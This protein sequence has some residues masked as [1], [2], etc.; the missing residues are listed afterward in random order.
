[1]LPCVRPTHI[2][3][4]GTQLPALLWIPWPF[5]SAIWMSWHWQ[6]TAGHR[7]QDEDTWNPPGLA[8]AE[9]DPVTLVRSRG[10]PA[11][12]WVWGGM[13]AHARWLFPYRPNS[14]GSGWWRSHPF[15]NVSAPLWAEGTGG[16]LPFCLPDSLLS[17][18]SGKGETKSRSHHP[19]PQEGLPV[20]T[21]R[22]SGSGSWWQRGSTGRTLSPSPAAASEP[23]CSAFLR[24]RGRGRAE[25][26]AGRSDR[27]GSGGV[28]DGTAFGGRLFPRAATRLCASHTHSSQGS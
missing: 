25:W 16:L 14:R 22:G 13:R 10:L 18:K 2:L 21:R 24:H 5:L 6:A 12:L 11:L 1:M 7:L 9:S 8:L 4:G 20:Q 28:P 23:V 17:L 27:A 26:R 15:P 3:P 19:V